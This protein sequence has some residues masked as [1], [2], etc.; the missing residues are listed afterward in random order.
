MTKTMTLSLCSSVLFTWL[1]IPLGAMFGPIVLFLFASKMGYILTLPTHTPTIVQL[2]L[3]LSIG[4]MVPSGFITRDLPI[5][6]FVGLV[7]CLLGQISLTYL[8]LNKK[9]RW[10]TTD[11]LLG[12]FP[13][14]ITAVLMLNDAQFTPSKKII[15]TH[16]VRLLSLVVLSG[17]IA[18]A[19][20]SDP[21]RYIYS[22]ESYWLLLAVAITWASGYTV[23]K[24][25]IPT[26]Y[27]VTGMLVSMAITNVMPQSN[28]TI[29]PIV[30]FIATSGL[31]AI[32]G[33]RLNNIT[34]Q[35]VITNLRSGLITTVLSLGVTVIFAFGFSQILNQRFIVILLSWMPGSIESIMVTAIYLGLEPALIML[36]HIARMMI[37]HSL[38]LITKL[39]ARAPNKHN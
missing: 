4:M 31:G 9:E 8:W 33:C 10:S 35:D 7:I 14:A 15:F 24:I 5:M 27:M 36:N 39:S 1:H 18:S 37:L 17:L 3:G 34:R 21:V 19:S 20:P 32:I 11:S 26:P 12:S 38:P 30:V 23:E 28:I 2:I 29:P 6:M 22:N 16:V 13:G 25:G